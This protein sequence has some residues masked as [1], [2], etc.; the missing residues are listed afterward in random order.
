MSNAAAV[1][2]ILPMALPIAESLGADPKAVTLAVAV[3]S[4]L[5]FL[6]P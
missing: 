5:A 1:G 6:F 4:G 3:S 2:A